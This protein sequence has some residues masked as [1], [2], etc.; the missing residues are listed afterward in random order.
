LNSF[1]QYGRYIL[2]DYDHQRPFSSFLPGIAG[3]QGIPMW[4]FYVNRGQAVCSFGVEDKDHPIL[5]FQAANKAYQTTAL[6]GFRTFLNGASAGE[7]WHR[8]AFSPW[9]A[10]DAKRTMFIGMNEVEIQEINHGLGYQINV[11]V[12]YIAQSALFRACQAGH[13]EKYRDC[14]PPT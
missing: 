3:L 13:P 1:D 14:S 6:M 5:E 11:L 12:F 8:E 2:A 4:V 9:E 7:R 10:V